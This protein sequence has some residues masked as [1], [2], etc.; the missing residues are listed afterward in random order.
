MTGVPLATFH[1]IYQ[2]RVTTCGI[3]EACRL[4]IRRLFDRIK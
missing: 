1:D 2:R 4:A 3:F